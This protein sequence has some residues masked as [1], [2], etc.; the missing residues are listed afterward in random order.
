[1]RVEWAGV[2]FVVLSHRDG[3]RLRAPGLWAFVRRGASGERTLL[4]VDHSEDMAA[5]AGPAHARWPDA[6]VLGL[7]EL[8]VCLAARSRVDRL[9]LRAHLIRRTEPLLNVLD[10]ALPPADAAQP[11]GPARRRA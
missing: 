8:H 3:A 6:L 2:S 4:W 7:N 9:Q 5:E 10:E 1:M 11:D